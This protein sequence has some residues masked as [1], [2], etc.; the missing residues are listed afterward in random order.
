MGEDFDYRKEFNS[1][2]LTALKKD[3]AALMTD[4]QDWWP[5]TSVTTGAC[6]FAWRGTAPAPTGPG[7]GVVA[8]QGPT[9]LSPLCAWPDNVNLDKARR[10][11]WPSA[12]IRRQD[13]L[14]DLIILTGNVAWSRWLAHIRLRWRS[15][16]RLGTGSGCVLGAEKVWLEDNR[17]SGDRDLEIPS[18][19]CRWA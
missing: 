5:R 13:F 12:E 9:A 17:H 15:R 6:S 10:L 14:A 11:L 3:L 1:L 4:S 18:L 16:R 7:T 8:A 2:D 19:P